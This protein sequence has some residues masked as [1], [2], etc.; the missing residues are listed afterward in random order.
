MSANTRAFTVASTLLLLAACGG[1][2][3][4]VPRRVAAPPE[5]YE[6]DGL[7]VMMDE[8]ESAPLERA[9]PWTEG[10]AEVAE[11]GFHSTAREPLSTFSVDVDTASYS[12]VRR[13]LSYDERPPAEAVRIEELINYFDYAYPEP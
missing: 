10:Y 3:S 7:Q 12:N 9:I 2:A 5:S 6:A 4:Y 8:A 13:F 11:T 1:G